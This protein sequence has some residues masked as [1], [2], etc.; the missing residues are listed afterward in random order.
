[1]IIVILIKNMLLAINSLTLFSFRLC[2][3]STKNSEQAIWKI[4]LSSQ[5]AY[6]KL[7]I[8]S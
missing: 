4:D 8:S 2:P 5:Q 1:M 7:D 3:N 6:V